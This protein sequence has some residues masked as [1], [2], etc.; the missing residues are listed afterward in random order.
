MI[1]TDSDLGTNT[2]FSTDI[3]RWF[4]T[5]SEAKEVLDKNVICIN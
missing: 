2:R 3:V 1:V 5:Y 4:D